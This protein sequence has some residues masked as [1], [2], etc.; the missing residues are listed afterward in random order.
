MVHN[1]GKFKGKSVTCSITVVQDNKSCKYFSWQ[2]E[3][4]KTDMTIRNATN[5][6]RQEERFIS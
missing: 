2:E 3:S 1:K 5:D 4:F 6:E